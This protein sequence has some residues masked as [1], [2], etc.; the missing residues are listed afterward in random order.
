[1]CYIIFIWKNIVEQI[2]NKFCNCHVKKKNDFHYSDKGAF[3]K[4]IKNIILLL[5]DKH[6]LLT[7]SRA[8]ACDI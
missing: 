6:E 4:F 2:L 7:K 3:Y 8:V 5:L 1:M